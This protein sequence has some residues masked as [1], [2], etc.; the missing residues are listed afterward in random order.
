ERARVL[1]GSTRARPPDAGLAGIGGSGSGGVLMCGRYVSPEDAADKRSF[2][3][4]SPEA[5]SLA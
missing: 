3:L 5:A 4:E 1:G 2:H